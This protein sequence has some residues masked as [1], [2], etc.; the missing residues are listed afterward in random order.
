MRSTIT[1][2]LITEECLRRDLRTIGVTPGTTL[3]VHS[4][5]SAIGWVL[6][7]APTV[8][9]ALIDAVG[10]DGNLAMSA[11][12]PHCADPATWRDLTAPQAWLEEMGNHLPLFD[13]RT[14]PTTMGAI[15]EVFRNWPGTLRSDHPLESVCVRGPH[16]AA[17][18]RE[19]P[20]AF[21]EGTGS[22][23]AKLHDLGSFILLLGVGF[24]RC[25][26]L[27]LAESLMPNRRTTNVRFP[28]FEGERRT[29]VEAPNVADD[30]DT[31]FPVI[32]EQFVASKGVTECLVGEARSVYF[33]M[34]DLVEFACAY[35]DRNLKG[36][37]EG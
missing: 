3:I 35:F 13:V 20:L 33:P 2:K 22:P 24:N 31:H 36:R 34:G 16:A 21:S 14:T 11:A 27:H 19:H 26:A 25:T 4:S 17:V 18:T 23:F 6:G 10:E 28:R 1:G 32:G 29:W 9:R 37:S 12:T 15:P 30:N 5:L 8:V 7:G